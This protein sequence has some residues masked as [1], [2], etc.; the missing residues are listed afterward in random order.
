[1]EKAAS[2]LLKVLVLWAVLLV[3]LSLTAMPCM[4]QERVVDY[5][6]AQTSDNV[7]GVISVTV[8]DTADQP[9]RGACIQLL[10]RGMFWSGVIRVR[11][12]DTGRFRLTVRVGTYD[13]FFS[14]PQV[15]FEAG[16]KRVVLTPERPVQNLTLPLVPPEKKCGPAGC[17]L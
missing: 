2:A 6:Q 12:T 16:P 9:V 5:R 1:M 10:P 11:C 7:R 15:Q 4:A 13:V 3:A 8:V 17:A 14:A